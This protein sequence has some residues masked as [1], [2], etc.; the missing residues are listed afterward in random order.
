M[1]SLSIRVE[2]KMASETV[3][4]SQSPTPAKK[5]Y[6]KK[7]KGKNHVGLLRSQLTDPA[8]VTKGTGKVGR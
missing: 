2:E 5:Q 8:M 6:Y 3:R 7:K 1:V 4:Y